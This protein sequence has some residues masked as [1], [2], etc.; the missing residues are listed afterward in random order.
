MRPFTGYEAAHISGA[1]ECGVHVTASAKGW[2]TYRHRQPPEKLR[3]LARAYMVQPAQQQLA[4]SLG[5]I[6]GQSLSHIKLERYSKAKQNSSKCE[7]AA[8]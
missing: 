7:V 3:G 8:S 1:S 2:G 5:N 6:S 4:L